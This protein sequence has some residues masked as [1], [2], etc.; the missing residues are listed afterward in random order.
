M[1]AVAFHIALSALAV[2]AVTLR[3]EQT[4]RRLRRRE[5]LRSIAVLNALGFLLDRWVLG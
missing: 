1:S 5:L 4:G 3:A 2:S